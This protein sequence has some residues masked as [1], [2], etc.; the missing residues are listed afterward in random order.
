LEGHVPFW[1][2]VT[3]NN[4]LYRGSLEGEEIFEAVCARM[5]SPPSV[6]YSSLERAN[7]RFDAI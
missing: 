1:P 5:A 3:I 2:A 7:V 4:V 6:C